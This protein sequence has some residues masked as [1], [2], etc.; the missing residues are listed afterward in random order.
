MLARLLV[1]FVVG[2]TL[3]AVVLTIMGFPLNMGCV[4]G[5][6]IGATLSELL[7]KPKT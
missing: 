6:A 5:A 4:V 1:S 2:L 7:F 3:A